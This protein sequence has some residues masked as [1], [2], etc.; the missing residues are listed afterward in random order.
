MIGIGSKSSSSMSARDK[1]VASRHLDLKDRD[2][3][4]RKHVNAV[5]KSRSTINTSEPD[6]PPRLQV[7]AVCNERH[8]RG[9]LRSFA[10]RGHLISEAVGRVPARASTRSRQKTSVARRMAPIAA[11]QLDVLQSRPPDAS[12][13]NGPSSRRI[14]RRARHPRTPARSSQSGSATVSNRLLRKRR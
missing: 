14:G 2:I 5:R 9:L 8:R 7:A 12:P 4:Y 3:S 6:V 13:A 10:D 11:K 1:P